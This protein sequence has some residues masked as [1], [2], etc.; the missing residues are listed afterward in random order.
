MMRFN[1][2][3]PRGFFA[4][5]SFVFVKAV[6]RLI[7]GQ[8]SISTLWDARRVSAG[9][10]VGVFAVLVEQH[11]C[12]CQLQGYHAKLVLDWRGKTHQLFACNVFADTETLYVF[13]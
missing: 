13:T 3:Q 1:I 4:Q 12:S 11:M 7:A 5:T 10:R 8:L 6:Y 9:E 2:N